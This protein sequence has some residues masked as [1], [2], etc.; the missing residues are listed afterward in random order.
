MRKQPQTEHKRMSVAV[1]QQNLIYANRWQAGRLNGPVG[2][3]LPTAVVD[4][5]EAARTM[6]RAWALEP[7]VCGPQPCCFLA[8]H[9][10]ESLNK[11]QEYRLIGLSW[12]SR[13][14]VSL[15]NG[16]QGW[17]LVNI[18]CPY[19]F[20]LDLASP[21]I[22]FFFFGA[23]GKGMLGIIL[24]TLKANAN[25]KFICLFIFLAWSLNEKKNMWPSLAAEKV[26]GVAQCCSFH[27][28]VGKQCS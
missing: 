17:H 26:I 16:A 3:C 21:L 28:W 15:K 4:V 10:G 13:E 22:F 6:A 11:G 2:F 24:G 14:T 25:W 23:G 18:S 12:E 5:G 7:G 1:F 27:S 8:L 19:L 9:L 20:P